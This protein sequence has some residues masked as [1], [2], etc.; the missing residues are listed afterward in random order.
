M[1]A[2]VSLLFTTNTAIKT[3]IYK[4]ITVFIATNNLEHI[5]IQIQIFAKRLTDYNNILKFL[6]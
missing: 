5:S 4:Q 1:V 2:F 3:P 6:L